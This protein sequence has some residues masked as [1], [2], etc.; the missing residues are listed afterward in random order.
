[1]RPGM[2]HLVVS[3]WSHSQALSTPSHRRNSNLTTIS[4]IV[5]RAR[6]TS[7]QWSR[8]RTTD[9]S[10]SVADRTIAIRSHTRF[11]SPSP[12]PIAFSEVWVRGRPPRA[13][14][15][16]SGGKHGKRLAKR[17]L[18]YRCYRSYRPIVRA[19]SRIGHKE[20]LSFLLRL[21]TE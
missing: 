2:E 20:Y 7:R 21:A 17:S 3:E 4:S 8:R 1:M 15:R 13:T 14:S 19:S 11:N 6:D 9:S 5:L 16:R 12:F 10:S 18:R